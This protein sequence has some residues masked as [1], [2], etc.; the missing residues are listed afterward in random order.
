MPKYIRTRFI[1]IK[2]N[3]R[4]KVQNIWLVTSLLDGQYP[5]AE[6]AELYLK[7]WSIETL[8]RQFKID[9]SADILRSRSVSAISKEIAARICAINIIHTLMLQAAILKKVDVSRISF[10][11]TV[12]AII[13]FAPA[14]ATKS[15]S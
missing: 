14:L 1:E 13:A 5:A 3:I 15:A 9:L 11:Y 4:G 2:V 7:R 12:R 6:I 10:V 8:F